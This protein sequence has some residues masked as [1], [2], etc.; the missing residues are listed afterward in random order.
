MRVTVITVA[1]GLLATVS[2]HATSFTFQTLDNP[3]D[4]TFN[5]LLGINDAGTIAGY[6]GSGAKGHPNKG[7]TIAK[8]YTTFVKA[9][10]PNSVQ[11]QATG[12]NAA[13][14]ITGFYAL[15]NDANPAN[16]ANYGFIRQKNSGGGFTFTQVNDPNTTSTPPVNQALGINKN[17]NS[18]GFYLD[19]A[20]NSHGFAFQLGPNTFTGITLNNAQ[21]VAATGIND[22]NLICGFFVN[23]K[24]TL[25]GG[26]IKP[27]SGKGTTIEYAQ[28][29]A[30]LTQFLGINNMGTTVGFYQGK[31]GIPHGLYFDPTTKT[32]TTVDNP[33]GTQGNVINGLNNMGQLVGFYTDNSGNTH[34][35]I[36][37]VGP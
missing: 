3:A 32:A 33:A 20:G 14:T 15:T 36:V 30:P 11:T 34:G 22:N 23:A 7:Y 5:Q 28:K 4:P 35:E 31:D 27:E 12:I 17:N 25:T 37:T 21:Q 6:Y 9:N 18:V 26:F 1:V 2:A 10:Y 29:G 13:G 24:G 8:P 19:S 16:N